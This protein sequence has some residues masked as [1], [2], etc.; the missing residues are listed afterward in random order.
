MLETYRETYEA[1]IR[2]LAS[3]GH[4]GSATDH[5]RRAADYLYAQLESLDFG[6]TRES[7]AGCTSFGA[8]I[9]LHVVI[10]MV[11]AVCFWRWPLVDCALG[12]LALVS[13]WWEHATSSAW[14]SR[15]L[16]RYPSANVVGHFT[17]P[18][19]RLRVILSGHYDT[20]RTGAI[21]W[22]FAYFGPLFWWVPAFLKPPLLSL[23]FTMAVQIVLGCLA[24]FR[25][26]SPP[27]AVVNGLVLV[28]YFIA[29]VLLGQ[30]AI[31]RFVQGAGDNA[32][33]AA[34][35]LTLGEAWRRQP[36]P[37]VELVLLLT[38]CEEVG[39]IGSAE[40]V[41]R[42]RQELHELPTIF[43]NLDNLGFGPPR[44]FSS[45]VPLCGFPIAYPPAMVAAAVETARDLGL[46]D[47]CPHAM[48]GPTDA[49]SFLA[50]GMQGISIV[51]FR[52]WGFMPYY[53]RSNDTIEN[54]DLD[55]AWQAVEFGWALLQR[56][57]K[58]SV[59]SSSADSGLAS[60]SQTAAQQT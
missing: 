33:G 5:E 20:Q 17:V 53:H 22:L 3:L 43:L 39:Q 34:A 59:G 51:S 2:A 45:E 19:P 28:A 47:A 32:T 7:F 14:L 13:F 16:L 8:R 4:R 18:S 54:L 35:V 56:M 50:R 44:F 37:D 1:R 30:W 11:G 29:V 55:A 58:P 24:A 60:R 52:R 41:E 27:L 9:L 12:L 49:L 21:W 6:P 36:L 57:A 15:L 23:A 10:A 25:G 31:G 26:I 48:P 46:E 42:H 38:G 40:W